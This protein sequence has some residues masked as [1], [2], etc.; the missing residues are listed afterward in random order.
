M[1]LVKLDDDV[2]VNPEHVTLVERSTRGTLV[3]V[4]GLEFVYP[5]DV[6]EVLDRLDPVSAA[7]SESGFCR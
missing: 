4:G 5:L 7:A 3:R 1:K 6:Y 2:W